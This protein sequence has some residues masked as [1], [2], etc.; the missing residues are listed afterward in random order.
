NH[1]RRRLVVSAALA[2]V[3]FAA[4]AGLASRPEF[5]A[6]LGVP[7]ASS[8]AAL[9]LFVIAAPALTFFATPLAS[10]WSRRH[11]LAADDFAVRQT[12]ARAL[13]DALLKLYRD[14]PANLAPDRF[15]SAFYDTHPPAL[16]RVARLRAVPVPGT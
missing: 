5:Y 12:S 4:L 11:E 8:H 14:N 3:G 2:L 7:T 6:A 16:V 13:A 1:V 15:F 10:G 9:L